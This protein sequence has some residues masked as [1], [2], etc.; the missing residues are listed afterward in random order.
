MKVR[1]AKKTRTKTKKSKRKSIFV[2]KND[3]DAADVDLLDVEVIS[4]PSNNNSSGRLN[5]SV[6]SLP[7]KLISQGFD[8]IEVVAEEKLN[9]KLPAKASAEQIEKMIKKEG[10]A[11]KQRRKQSIAI[12]LTKTID[13][14]KLPSLVKKSE[15]EEDEEEETEF[16]FAK[17]TNVKIKRQTIR[18]EH[19]SGKSE[20][21]DRQGILEVRLGNV[22]SN[23]SEQT[24]DEISDQKFDFANSVLGTTKNSSK[25]RLDFS[26]KISDEVEDVPPVHPLLKILKS[27]VRGA[28]IVKYQNCKI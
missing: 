28:V 22:G 21:T 27:K 3:K 13:K 10:S 5:L 9:E 11:K 19:I 1:S 2:R 14:K 17:S 20:Q 12:D 7:A 25:E 18:S 16:R 15:F 8:K 4:A 6:S 23:V 26:R 24:V